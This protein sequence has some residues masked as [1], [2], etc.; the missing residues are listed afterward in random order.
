MERVRATLK[1]TALAHS[2]HTETR[3]L[4]FPILATPIAIGRE[5]PAFPA[6]NGF[7]FAAEGAFDASCFSHHGLVLLLR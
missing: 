3:E 4:A 5:W 7:T 6:Q 1:T 2:L